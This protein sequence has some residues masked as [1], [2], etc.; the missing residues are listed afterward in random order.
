[1]QSS[2]WGFGAFTPEMGRHPQ[3]GVLPQNP[4]RRICAFGVA[5]KN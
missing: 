2:V 1:M 5:G 4:N 3:R